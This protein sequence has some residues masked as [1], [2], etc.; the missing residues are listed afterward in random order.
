[1]VYALSEGLRAALAEGLEARYQRHLDVAAG[2][3]RG[4]EV[5]GLECLV[6]PESRTPMLTTVVLP[7]G[8]D[9]APAR[10]AMREE[11]R[12]EIGGGLGPLKGRVWRIGLMGYGARIQCVA[13]VLA[14]IGDALAKASPGQQVDVPAAMRA[15][16]RVILS[17]PWVPRYAAAS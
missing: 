15:A 7:D 12:I 6:A 16:A 10:L 11:H 14:A 13:R 9:E 8:F 2:L 5:L 1:M 17:G 4:L 3:Y